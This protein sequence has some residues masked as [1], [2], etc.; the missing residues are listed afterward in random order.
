[1]RRGLPAEGRRADRPGKVKV[2]G[3]VAGLGDKADPHKDIVTVGGRRIAL[4]RENAI[5]CCT[6][7]AAMSPP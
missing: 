6:S 5:L 2:N 1:M 3:H 4:P 7:R